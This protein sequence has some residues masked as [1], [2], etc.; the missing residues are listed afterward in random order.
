MS[1]VGE[2]EL[3]LQRYPLLMTVEEAAEVL[4]IGRSLAH[5]LARR[6]EQSVGREGLPVIRLGSCL[7]V[8]RWALIELLAIGR[9]VRLADGRDG[10]RR[11][12]EHD[13][14][15]PHRHQHA[16]QEFADR[17][18]RGEASS[19]QEHCV[20][21]RPRRPRSKRSAKQLVLL[22]SD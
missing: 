1:V 4:R 12:V 16:S 8:P 20:S 15:S 22:P 10:D 5:A 17:Q 14:L 3:A 13:R 2:L 6:Y 18:S 9:I 19:A 11:L 7:R 21:T